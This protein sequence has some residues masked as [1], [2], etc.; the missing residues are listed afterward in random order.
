MGIKRHGVEQIVSK[1]RQIEVSM[2]Q[3]KALAAARKDAAISEQSS[4]TNS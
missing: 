4:A 1:L 2:S 3:G